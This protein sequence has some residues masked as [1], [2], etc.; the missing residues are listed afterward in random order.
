MSDSALVVASPWPRTGSTNLFAAQ[1]RYLATR[2]FR[3]AML[4]APHLPIHRSRNAAFW[5]DTLAAVERDCRSHPEDEGPDLIAA[6]RSDQR[7]R[8]WRSVGFY[9]WLTHGR[10]S[11]LAVM[12]R[13]A[14]AATLPPELVAVL[15]AHD[16]RLIIA[17]HC[18]QMGTV[19]TVLHHLARRG[20]PR[21]RVVLETQDVQ[22]EL[23]AVGKIHN[24]FRGEPDAREVLARDELRLVAGADALTHVTA[25]DL[26]YFRA[27]APGRHHLTLA[28]L[29]PTTEHRLLT[30]P[31]EPPLFDFLYVGNVNP[32]NEIS[33]TWFLDEVA[34]RLAP[35]I[36]VAIVGPIAS[37]LRT[38]R[39][40]L[41]ARWWPW[42]LGDVDDIADVYRRSA[43]VILPTRFGTGISIKTIEALAAGRPVIATSLALR[44]L[45]IEPGRGG[46]AVV[47]DAAGFADAME[48]V[49][50]QRSIRAGPARA[51]YSELFSNARY[52]ARWDVVLADLGISLPTPAS[53]TPPG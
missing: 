39:P 28:T 24:S 25:H 14:R 41:H 23:Y 1:A 7:L 21:P 16:L 52:F 43:A 31:E 17:S 20:R 9:R 11:Q 34:P 5:R 51:L 53:A 27:H 22:A 46:V 10:D 49:R 2:G 19:E 48:E 38:I 6:G 4:L 13:Y 26:D 30:L 36:R 35:D 50:R 47:D 37:R 40:D 12:A 29:A 18:F 45:P 44:G 32:G 42:C 8:R 3:T 33:L 15:D